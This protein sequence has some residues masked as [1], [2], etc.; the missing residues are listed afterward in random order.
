MCKRSPKRIICKTCF[1]HNFAKDPSFFTFR[2]HFG[3]FDTFG[4][5]KKWVESVE[6]SDYIRPGVFSIRGLLYFYQTHY[7]F[8]EFYL[9]DFRNMSQK[10]FIQ[11]ISTEFS[12]DSIESSIVQ[13]LV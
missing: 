6:Y 12:E 11:N 9:F 8:M 2:F 7:G 5:V 1:F 13:T 10:V 3:V 4:L